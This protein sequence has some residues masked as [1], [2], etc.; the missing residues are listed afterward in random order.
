[1]TSPKERLLP[2]IDETNQK[3]IDHYVNF[4]SQMETP[5][6]LGEAMFKS[7]ESWGAGYGQMFGPLMKVL[8]DTDS[9]IREEV[10]SSLKRIG[11]KDEWISRYFQ[12]YIKSGSY[13]INRLMD[14][15]PEDK[16]DAFIKES[17]QLMLD[18]LK[19]Y[20]GLEKKLQSE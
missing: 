17:D 7:G 18:I 4:L 10:H 1:M 6:D 13:M 12:K 3:H 20:A 19:R 9:G 5:D 15:V 2:L 16:K 8:Y 11:I 14:E